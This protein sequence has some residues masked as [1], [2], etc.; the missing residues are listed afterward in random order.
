MNAH[1]NLAIVLSIQSALVFL[2]VLAVGQGVFPLGVRGEW[3]WLRL[4]VS[5]TALDLTIAGLGVATLVVVAGWGWRWLGSSPHPLRREAVAVAALLVASVVGQVSVQT[6][7]PE[8][9]GLV[10]WAIA[11]E[12]PGSSG[13]ARIA[14]TQARDAWRFWAEY[15]SWIKTQDSL[16]IGTH[17]PGLILFARWASGLMHARPTI[18]SFVL[19]QAPGSIHAAFRVLGVVSR[20]DRA[21][22]VL[23]G[24]LT[25]FACSATVGPLYLLGRAS[26]LA[27]RSAWASAVLWPLVPS[28]ILF[29][30]TA[31]AAYPL[32]STTALAL[33]AWGRRDAAIGAGVVLGLGMQFSLVFLPVGMIAAIMTLTDPRRSMRDRVALVFSVGLGF[34]AFTLAAWAVSGANPFVIWWW[35]QKHHARFYVEFPRSYRAWAFANL[36][37]L[38][39]AL[40]LATSTLAAIGLKSAPR[41]AWATL[42]VILI[43]NFSGRNL[44]E[45]ARL[46]L[47]LMP[48]LLLAAGRTFDRFEGKAAHPVAMVAILGVQTVA[49]QS[50]IQV[51]YPV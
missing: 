34:V 35:N 47:P 42:L 14:R 8:G 1:R 18:A 40:G 13:Y 22:L 3:E 29:Q 48:P 28:A 2:F 15:P 36:I 43:L 16:H 46:W 19:D 41:S 4:N 24:A 44:G 9:Y 49:L 11:L 37:E 50:L 20:P 12:N 25:L 26:G 38:A 6:G 5:P 23:T 21:A 7:A 32:L 27:P 45:V 30:P 51:V 39:V 33:V 17:P 31:D 10:K